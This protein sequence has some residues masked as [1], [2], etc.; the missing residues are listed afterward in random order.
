MNFCLCCGH[1]ISIHGLKWTNG[2]I[3]IDAQRTLISLP[4]L[5]STSPLIRYCTDTLCILPW[6]VQQKGSSTQGR[7]KY[8]L[9]TQRTLFILACQHTL[10]I[11]WFPLFI[12]WCPS[13]WHSLGTRPANHPAA[14]Q[15]VGV[16]K[17][18]THLDVYTQTL[19]V[20]NWHF[21]LDNAHMYVCTAA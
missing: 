15:W 21:Y 9:P 18:W 3:W 5:H 17:A 4:S 12:I 2:W 8:I 20:F 10:N 16:R 11:L 7:H 14:S 19:I 1:A 6:S 13:D